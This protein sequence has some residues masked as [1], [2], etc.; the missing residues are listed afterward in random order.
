MVSNFC[1]VT[2][3]VLL[4]RLLKARAAVSAGR[5]VGGKCADDLAK[6]KIDRST[7][8]N[9]DVPLGKAQGHWCY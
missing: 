3:A 5:K 4:E 1:G 6:F 7:N 9:K 8:I 2:A